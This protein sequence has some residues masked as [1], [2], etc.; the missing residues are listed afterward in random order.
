MKEIKKI[1][2]KPVVSKPPA[3]DARLLVDLPLLSDLHESV[4][5]LDLSD[6]ED[7][8]LDI[9]AVVEAMLLP[10]PPSPPSPLSSVEDGDGDDGEDGETLEALH[11][12]FGFPNLSNG[13]LYIDVAAGY[14]LKICAVDFS[15]SAVRDEN[16]ASFHT[17]IIPVEVSDDGNFTICIASA[18]SMSGP[19]VT[20]IKREAFLKCFIAVTTEQKRGGKGK[21]QGKQLRPIF[22]V[23]KLLG[24]SVSKEFSREEN[25][26]LDEYH[27]DIEGKF[28]H[29]CA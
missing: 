8:D 29:W 3:E 16:E 7:P 28:A 19:S 10:L 2:K 20:K 26:M 9:K 17:T 14:L 4:S 22:P 15:K 21:W 24:H 1:G 11:D 5:P 27:K 12:F 6:L 23:I 13:Q 18:P 25:E